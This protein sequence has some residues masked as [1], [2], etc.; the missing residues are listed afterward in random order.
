[1]T[2][3]TSHGGKVVV[4]ALKSSVAKNQYPKSE[5]I[6]PGRINADS[7]SPLSEKDMVKLQLLKRKNPGT[8][9]LEGQINLGSEMDVKICTPKAIQMYARRKNKN[10][11]AISGIFVRDLRPEVMIEDVNCRNNS[12]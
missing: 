6:R 5:V 12:G 1:M 8:K 3:C 4:K 9:T 11:E 2:H 7:T 10:G